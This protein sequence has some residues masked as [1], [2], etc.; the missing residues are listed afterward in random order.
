MQDSVKGCE[1]KM[2]S[3]NVPY[4]QVP[5]QYA[6]RNARRQCLY[7]LKGRVYSPEFRSPGNLAQ[8]PCKPN[9]QHFPSKCVEEQ[10]D[11]SGRE[12]KLLRSYKRG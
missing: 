8:S 11:A 10:R 1:Q 3:I 2:W 7:K 4:H 9:A 5:P 12:I 6:N